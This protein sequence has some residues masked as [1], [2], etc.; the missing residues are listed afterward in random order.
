MK[1][2]VLQTATRRVSAPSAGKGV[3]HT[4]RA[5]GG[6][7]QRMWCFGCCGGESDVGETKPLNPGLIVEPTATYSSSGE[8]QVGSTFVGR[9][10]WTQHPTLLNN[11]YDVHSKVSDDDIWVVAV[12]AGK[13]VAT[14]YLQFK[15]KGELMSFTSFESHPPFSGLGSI[16]LAL[17]RVKANGRELAP[18][19]PVPGS[20]TFYERQ[21][22]EGFNV[23]DRTKAGIGRIMDRERDNIRGA[24]G[25]LE[26]MD[27]HMMLETVQKEIKLK[28]GL[29]IATGKATYTSPFKK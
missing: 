24:K 20:Y 3:S 26:S 9:T 17:L 14:S 12:Y 13:V 28:E 23:S 16:A 25:N 15:V 7:V 19:G 4:H 22:F 6:V 2:S 8:P 27:S 11:K 29:D 1:P 10:D 21:G 5:R 18:S